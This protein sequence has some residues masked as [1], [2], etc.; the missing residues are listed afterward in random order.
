MT[1]LRAVSKPQLTKMCHQHSVEADLGPAYRY[2]NQPPTAGTLGWLPLLPQLHLTLLGQWSDPRALGCRNAP[3]GSQ[4]KPIVE[5]ALSF[6]V[7]PE[8]AAVFAHRRGS[9]WTIVEINAKL[10]DIFQA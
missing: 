2:P 10:P 9:G 7:C 8:T 4:R 5:A 1:D 3:A 6:S